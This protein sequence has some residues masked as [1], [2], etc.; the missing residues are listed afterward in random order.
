M[1]AIPQETIDNVIVMLDSG[2]STRAI[3]RETG[4]STGS[5]SNLINRHCPDLYRRSAGRPSKLSE[6]DIRF[7][8]RAITYY[9]CSVECA[10]ENLHN[11][12]NISQP[13]GRLI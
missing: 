4:I 3:A 13:M 5:V 1:K 8:A 6:N 9:N 7:A 11:L 10:R 12:N 2:Q